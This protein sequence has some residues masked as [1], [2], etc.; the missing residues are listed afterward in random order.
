MISNNNNNQCD[1]AMLHPRLAKMFNKKEDNWFL[2]YSNDKSKFKSATF[3][4]LVKLNEAIE[5]TCAELQPNRSLTSVLATLTHDLYPRLMQRSPLARSI[6][7]FLMEAIFIRQ[8]SEGIDVATLQQQPASILDLMDAYS[9]ANSTQD[10][11]DDGGADSG[12]LSDIE[13]L[14][15]LMVE[16]TYFDDCRLLNTELA[17]ELELCPDWEKEREAA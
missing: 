16:R 12:I 4:G 10:N 2:N 9:H 11:T 13:K 15:L 7:D 6:F 5:K 17:K 3:W 14:K 8:G 1:P